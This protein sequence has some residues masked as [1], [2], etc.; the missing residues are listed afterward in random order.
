[1]F[2]PFAFRTIKQ[3][4]EIIQYP[5]IDQSNLLRWYDANFDANSSTWNDLTTTQNATVQGNVTYDNTTSPFFYDFIGGAGTNGIGHTA[6]A[7]LS[8]SNL[9][10]QAWVRHSTTSNIQYCVASQRSVVGTAGVR[11][12][13]HLNPSANT[14]GIYNGGGFTTVG[15]VTQTSGTW[16]FFEFLMTTTATT[17]YQNNVSKGSIA[18][19]LNTTAGNEPFGI[20]TPNYNLSTYDSEYWKGDIGMILVY[21]TSTRPTGNWDATKARFGY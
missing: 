6:T 21:G 15:S 2:A 9:T 1:M 13:L 18:R 19:G 12:S 10:I 20:G 4:G 16:Y 11:Y 14:A 8:L 17:V 5:A 7:D 3:V